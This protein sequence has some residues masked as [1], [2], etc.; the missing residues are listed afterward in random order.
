MSK[1]Q[2]TTDHL[3]QNGEEIAIE[4]E[5]NCLTT[6]ITSLEKMSIL[7]SLDGVLDIKNVFNE[8]YRLKVEPEKLETILQTIRVELNMVAHHAYKPIGATQTR[9]YL[10][11]KITVKFKPGVTPKQVDNLLF[12]YNL[13]YVR[14]YSDSILLL[15]ITAATQRNPIKA[16]N[17][18]SAKR[19]VE[20][21]E[22]NLI[23][24][25]EPSFLP[26]DGKFNE[27]WHLK[28]TAGAELLPNADIEAMAAWDMTLG[29]RSIV[30]AI[31]DDGFDLRHPD[32][33]GQNKI[34]FPRNF[35][36]GTNSPM[37]EPDDY[38]GTPCAGLAI[39][40]ANGDGIVGVAP[41][42]SFM[43]VK[44]PFG[45]DANLLFDIFD[46]VGK[47]AHIISC[48]WGPPPV[49]A[50]LHQLVYDKIA[51]LARTGGPNGKGCTI[52]FAA[53]NF[54]TPL[55]DLD[56]TKGVRYMAGDRIYEHFDKIWNGNATHP[57]VIAVAAC[58]SLHQKALYSNWGKEIT[59]CAPSNNF[60]PFDSN[61]NLRGRGICTT[62]N[63][64]TISNYAPNSLYTTQF[65]GTSAAAPIVA[66]V[67]G[68]ILS[69][70]PHLTAVQVRQILIDTAD[71]ITDDSLD[72]I[73][74]HNKGFYDSKGH[75]EWFGYGKVNARKAVE[76]AKSMLAQPTPAPNSNDSSWEGINL[77]KKASTPKKVSKPQLVTFSTP[78]LHKEDG[79]DNVFQLSI[80]K[81]VAVW[82]ESAFANVYFEVYVQKNK[83]P[84]KRS[85]VARALH[86]VSGE[87]F[88]FEVDCVSDYY[89]R[90]IAPKGSGQYTVHTDLA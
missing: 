21:A 11:D 23:S 27:Q 84:T 62:D 30:I 57:D 17:E 20:Y 61:I 34:A 67:A 65:G 9:Y 74:Q 78:S 85:Y 36:T 5:L 73:W 12:Q 33:V 18:I 16:A 39:A 37:P 32:L 40:E 35:V 72:P 46:F 48:S 6:Y 3:W 69:A 63:F 79:S 66:G 25:F 59:I 80:G 19:T 13:R 42:C 71:K 52:I 60:H 49:Y 10:T 4:K 53:H 87:K 86:L 51:E 22:P 8:V 7:A 28:S 26:L 88:T 81:Q 70:N 24:R 1:L 58:T 56:N 89:V 14:S 31:L 55:K 38:H 77:P 50:P 2:N 41:R 83:P 75:S 64:G 82:I 43:P 68:L 15:Q 76:M 29:D 54:D 90:V 45:A 47:R 44:I